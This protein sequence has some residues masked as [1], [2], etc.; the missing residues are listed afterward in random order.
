MKVS[1]WLWNSVQEDLLLLHI[2]YRK[3]GYNPTL[4]QCYEAWYLYSEDMCANWIHI[5]NVEGSREYMERIINDDIIENMNGEDL[6][7]Q[8][9]TEGWNISIECKG[10]GRTYEMSYEGSAYMVGSDITER[11]YRYAEHHAV[12]DTLEELLN[13]MFNKEV[14]K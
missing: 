2:E 11:I 10:K 1:N 12:G 8:K 3:M 4:E 13:N 6:L 7:K 9:M 14:I 5:S